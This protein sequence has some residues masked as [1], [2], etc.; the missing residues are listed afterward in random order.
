MARSILLS[1]A[2]SLGRGLILVPAAAGLLLFALW[3]LAHTD[4]GRRLIVWGV[5]QASGDR[6]VLSGLSGRLPFAPRL[7][8]LEIR[9]AEGPWLLVEDAALDLDPAALL[10]GLLAVDG[11]S[12]GR[13][14]LSR[15]L[16]GGGEGGGLGL[17]LPLE[18]RQL[19]IA[20]L[21]LSG[22]I[23]SAPVLEVAGVGSAQGPERFSA[24]LTAS[25][26][27][28]ADEYRLEM[29][30]A[31][32]RWRLDLELAEDPGGLAVALLGPAANGIPPEWAA[33]RLRL[34]AAGPADALTLDAGLAAGPLR[35]AARGTLD[36]ASGR[37]DGLR[38]LG[39]LPAMS[40]QPWGRPEITWQ[41]MGLAADLSGSWTAPRVDGRL[42]IDGL[43]VAGTPDGD[44]A[45]A[46]ADLTLDAR[47]GARGLDLAALAR[48][49]RGPDALPPVAGEP[50][51]L[52]AWVRPDA[53]PLPFTLSAQ[54]ALVGLV[55]VGELGRRLAVGQ[56]VLPDL[57]ALS[58][59]IGGGARLDLAAS[60]EG[61]AR[62][63][64]NGAVALDAA[65][66]PLPRLLGPRAEVALSAAQAGDAWRIESARIQGPGLAASLA[67]L[68]GADRLDL[69]WTLG[70]TDLATLDPAWSGRMSADGDLSGTPAAPELTADLEIAAAHGQAGA[71]RAQGRV[72]ARLDPPAVSLDLTGDW[73]G[74]PLGVRLT[75]GRSQDGELRVGVAEGRF[76][77]ITASGDLALPAGAALPRGELAFDIPRLAEAAPLVALIRPGSL[78]DGASGLA[79][80]L[81]AL[82]AIDEAGRLSVAAQGEG[83]DLPGVA[84]IGVLS[85]DARVSDPLGRAETRASLALGDWAA[86]GLTGDLRLSASGPGAA[87]EVAAEAALGTPLGPASLDLAG[88]VDAP[89]RRLDLARLEAA[90][91]GETLSLRAPARLDLA[92]GLAVDRLRLAIGGGGLELAGRLTPRL[93]LETVIEGLS[94]DLVRLAAPDLPLAGT[95]SARAR[96]AGPLDAPTG[97]LDAE[98]IGVRL[99]Q[100]LYR[101]LPPGDLRLSASLD[102][103]G[104]RLDARTQAGA[105]TD[106]RLN[107]RIDGRLPEAIT[108]GAAALDLRADGPID[109]ALLSPLLAAGGQQVS[110]QVRVAAGVR[111]TLAAPRLSGTLGVAGAAFNDRTLGLSLTGIDG[112][113]RLD[114]ERV[115]V[116]RL[117]ASA[118]RGSLTLE[119]QIAPL[120]SGMPV[121]LR[122]SA[123][124]ARPIDLDLLKVRGDAD[125]R[126]SGRLR[127]RAQLAGAVSLTEV[128]IRLPERLPASVVTLEVSERGVPTRRR[129][130]ASAGAS[131]GVPGQGRLDLGLDLRVAAP[132]G[133]LVRG[134]GVDAEL[135][136]EVR[137]AGT[138]ARPQITGGFDLRRGEFLLASETL[139]FTRGRIGFDGAAGID[140]SIDLEAR[141]STADGTAIL[142]VLGTASTPRIAL[143]GEPEMP[144]DE[145][146]S[147][148]LFGVAGGRLSPLQATRLGIA[149]ASL[150]G[151][152]DE[153]VGV[154]DRV[155]SG[156]GLDRLVLGGGK[157]LGL[158]E[159]GRYIGRGFYLGA[160]QGPRSGEPQG[161]LRMEI[162]PRLRLEADV[163][164]TGGTRAGAAFERE[165]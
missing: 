111:G 83:L 3:G 85:L 84:R 75:A 164:A 52:S 49:L 71:G 105:G 72:D 80:R 41:A 16:A 31:D 110:G 10:G 32:G 6:V 119:G 152:G 140:P 106:L 95:L 94:L 157:W 68:A 35:V 147:R 26:P 113:L 100:G 57:A 63:A 125:L 28:R 137:L 163:G 33:P 54:H 159:G 2:R 9:D 19:A 48:G 47:G 37:A 22:V 91:G 155:R 93:D 45:W 146:L 114:G 77:G 25:A 1:A 109:L 13:V 61:G 38:V 115:L 11:L 108:G 128:D 99:T 67:G 30:H 5:G 144:D 130:P 87:L 158:I 40:G 134:R 20:R 97:T 60:L 154:L 43:S 118:G 102:T 29:D 66:G 17:P 78:G 131:V 150:A 122:L 121:D 21:D 117:T 90:L 73:S 92:D 42:G 101:G 138:L 141:V 104:T 165:Y 36:P 64:V 12:A 129:L 70:L 50:L 162:T 39:S 27:G 58:P 4:T 143:R 82:L 8:R 136:G 53:P 142:N 153:G 124:D 139:R 56:I 120:A 18:V 86:G 69:G 112:T 133:V 145:V 14:V 79:G 89:D 107:G 62:I 51:F 127:E 46:V 44:A 132:R 161:V 96:L 160:R 81:G 135:G 74:E 34:S 149:A 123:R 55:S 151:L 76:A 116:P 23:P 65:P 88:R 7:E 98:L 24:S 15:P 156:L 126:L 103:T 59:G 148:L